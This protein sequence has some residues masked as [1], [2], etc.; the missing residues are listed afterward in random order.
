MFAGA[1]REAVSSERIAKKIS[2]SF[3]P[4][5]LKAGHVNR[6]GRDV[7]GRLYEQ[8]RRTRPAPQGFCVV[9]SAGQ[10]LNWALSFDDEAGFE[11]FLD[12]CVARYANH[13]RGDSRV[14]AERHHRFPSAPMPEIPDNGVRVDLPEEFRP[15]DFA[16]SVIEVAPGT[17]TGRVVGR[18]VGGDGRVQADTTRQENYVEDLVRVSRQDQD[19]LVRSAMES[20]GKAF[21]FPPG[22]SRALVDGAYLGQLD[23][24]PLGGRQVGGRVD[25]ERIHFAGVRDGTVKEGKSTLER[26]LIVGSSDAVGGHSVQRVGDGRR[27][28]HRVALSWQGFV[29]LDRTKGRVARLMMLGEGE[30][31]LRWDNRA[32]E[33][34]KNPIAHLPAGRPLAVRTRVRYGITVE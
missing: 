30:E 17:K 10:V 13:P 20:E 16:S 12:H 34:A 7:E 3:V 4:V 29:L 27:W 5:A 14:A 1:A 8:I 18:A 25:R 32:P 26:Y 31:F 9:N 21:V 22:V 2:E 19:A 15:E 28:S 33:S 11:K 23:V 24:N 6:P